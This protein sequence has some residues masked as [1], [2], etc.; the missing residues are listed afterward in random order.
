MPIR[1]Y[2]IRLEIYATVHLPL[3]DDGE[4]RNC[5]DIDDAVT[6]RDAIE[7]AISG[8]ISQR[9]EVFVFGEDK[10]PAQV[11]IDLDLTNDMHI[12]GCEDE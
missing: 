3:P 1:T 12:E 6:D 2:E 7:A 9:R 8:A 4:D 10:D 11:F 5:C